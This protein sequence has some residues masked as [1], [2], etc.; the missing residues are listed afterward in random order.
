MQRRLL[1]IIDKGRG[2]NEVA[3]ARREGRPDDADRLLEL[4]V[5]TISHSWLWS[6]SP[7]HGPTLGSEDYAMAAR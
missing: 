6:L 3:R 1:Q 5:E 2:D 7:A 4:Q